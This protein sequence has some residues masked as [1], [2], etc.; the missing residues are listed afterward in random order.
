[1]S[2]EKVSDKFFV[3]GKKGYSFTHAFPNYG[4]Y[5]LQNHPS[6]SLG[7]C[8]LKSKNMETLNI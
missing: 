4:Y 8:N 6:P 7:L 1:M 2:T 5:Q 3:W